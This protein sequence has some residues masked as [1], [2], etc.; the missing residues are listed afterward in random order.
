MAALAN[1][2]CGGCGRWLRGGLRL[3]VPPASLFEAAVAA[4]LGSS[5]ERRRHA[6]VR[7]L[8][9]AGVGDG[10]KMGPRYNIQRALHAADVAGQPLRA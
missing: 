6:V 5:M 10:R 3:V 2:R 7:P 9:L 4:L 1:L 8:P